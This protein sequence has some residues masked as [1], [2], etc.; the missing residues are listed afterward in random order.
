[1]NDA[2]RNAGMKIEDTVRNASGLYTIGEAATYAKMPIT[3]LGYWLYGDRKHPALRQTRIAKDEGRFLTFLEFV[4]ALAI[5]TLRHTYNLPLQQIRT[6]LDICKAE[7]KIEYPFSDK[8]HQTSISGKEL[9]INFK[10]NPNPVQLTGKNKRQQSFRPCVEPFMRDLVF[11]DKRTAKAYIAHRYP[12]PNEQTINITM[13]PSY[14]FGD[15]VVDG[16]GYRAETLWKAAV[17]EGS[18]AKA[19]E[20]YEVSINHVIAACQYCDEIEMPA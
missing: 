13:N 4:E 1:M 12:V 16:T 20:F 2:N 11:D 8:E 3:T 5:R 15:P 17:A 10:G 14:C 6:A 7:Y 18:E 19:A 9:L